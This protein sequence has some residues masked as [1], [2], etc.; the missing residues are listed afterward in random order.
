MRKK[1]GRNDPCPCASGRKFKNCHLGRSQ[2]Q[3]QFGSEISPELEVM[4]QQ[5]LSQRQAMEKQRQA[6]QGLGRPI[7]S[8]QFKEWR[9]VAVGNQLMYSK[10]WKTAHD[11][12]FDYV[13]KT[14]GSEWGNAEIAKP[15]E[16]RHPIMVWYEHLCAYQKKYIG[17]SGAIKSGPETGATA[18]YLRL[19]YDLYCLAHNAKLQEKLIQRLKNK[20]QFRGALYETVVAACFVRAGFNIEFLDEDD[21]S[22]THCEF[23]AKHPSGNRYS[24]EAKYRHRDEED[25]APGK[26]KLGRL[27]VSALKKEADFTRI[28]FIDLAVPGKSTRADVE[29]LLYGA[30]GLLSNFE[31][32][33]FKDN[34][35]PPAYVVINNQP[36]GANLDGPAIP[37]AGIV[38]SYRIPEFSSRT[39]FSSFRE[40]YKARKRHADIIDLAESIKQ[41]SSV[42]STFDG[43]NPEYA[44]AEVATPRLI[45]GK[46][47]ELPSPDGPVSGILCDAVMNEAE[48]NVTGIYRLQNG[49]QELYSCPVSDAEIAAYRQHPD[50]FFG[51]ERTNSIKA[52]DPFE[53][54][55]FMLNSYQK[56][57]KSKLLELMK[58]SPDVAQLEKLPHEDLVEIYAERCTNAVLAQR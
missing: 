56:T 14:L 31:R 8:S 19:A 46:V 21:R 10:K 22:T 44:F 51:V 34:S 2:A 36:F 30:V 23:V 7:I 15:I 24:V 26:F 38:D 25:G 39:K 20:Q 1:V 54:F 13:K 45:I 11:F 18:A 3:A 55:M 57:P 5:Q 16:D 48:K 32:T 52:D 37:S 9:F 50:T 40:A 12:L 33:Q 42:P 28:V 35:L 41:H 29:R 53:L 58:D 6:Q 47:Y 49:R 4:I 27:L 43:E 17:Q